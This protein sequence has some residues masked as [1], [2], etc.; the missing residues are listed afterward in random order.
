MLNK[1]G[2]FM[3]FGIILISFSIVTFIGGT[4]P[5]IT[6]NEKETNE[7]ER[8]FYNQR[9]FQSANIL[10]ISVSLD[11]NQL[12]LLKEFN[13]KYE[14]THSGVY[15]RLN[16]YHKEQAYDE[17]I[18]AS[19]IGSASDI[20]LVE[21]EWI[22]EF[23]ASG[24]LIQL[25]EI[26]NSMDIEVHNL[27]HSQTKW[28]GFDWA[29][30]IDSDMYVW[31]WNPDQLKE[32]NVFIQPNTIE[33]LIEIMALHPEKVYVDQ[34]DPYS[35]LQ[36]ISMLN[37]IINDGSF[38]QSNASEIQWDIVTR[39][40]VAENTWELLNN[41]EILLKLTTLKDY[42][43][44]QDENYE[45]T[46]IYLESESVNSSPIGGVIKGSSFVVSSNTN[47]QKEAFEWLQT[48]LV[49]PYYSKIFDNKRVDD[50][51]LDDMK[52]LKPNPNLPDQLNR[53]IQDLNQLYS[54][55]QSSFLEQY[56]TLWTS[57]W[58]GYDQN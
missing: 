18:Q 39:F 54:V 48:L 11:E 1:K 12:Q 34:K 51:Q 4:E 46:P 24:Y 35:M 3:F 20:F 29:V 33:N 21:N 31:V 52:A 14:K 50:I 30:P 41:G 28:N 40:A 47:V 7:E 58:M 13:N 6:I 2:L 9:E 44:H 55:N 23:A 16:S 37:S 26:I 5:N 19:Q 38:V 8:P 43:N 49:D 42:Y 15:I 22:N 45:Y 27:L 56:S 57:Q 36:I 25:D 32:T 53:F 17:F 10:E